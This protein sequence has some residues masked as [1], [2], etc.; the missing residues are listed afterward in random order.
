[1]LE[2]T[3]P[4]EFMKQALLRRLADGSFGTE[5]RDFGIAVFLFFIYLFPMIIAPPVS[6]AEAPVEAVL[7]GGLALAGLL[8]CATIVLAPVGLVLL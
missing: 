4:F 7:V 5:M 3:I 8:L 6:L 2:L 1:M